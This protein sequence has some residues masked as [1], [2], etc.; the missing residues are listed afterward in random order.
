LRRRGRLFRILRLLRRRQLEKKVL[1][2]MV[3]TG[4]LARS[5]EL[6]LT[7]AAAPTGIMNCN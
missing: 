7:G 2:S 6:P 1:C 5:M 4:V 3:K